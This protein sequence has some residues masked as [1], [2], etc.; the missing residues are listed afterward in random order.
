MIRGLT[1]TGFTLAAAPPSIYTAGAPMDATRCRALTRR[2]Y[3]PFMSGDDNRQSA[4]ERLHALGYVV[5]HGD[6]EQRLHIDV[7]L[8]LCIV[9]P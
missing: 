3:G 4:V 6:A 8:V 7:V 5:D 9:D 2:S 1:P